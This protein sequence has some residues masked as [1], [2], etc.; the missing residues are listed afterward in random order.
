M[1]P[2]SSH[3]S[4]GCGSGRLALAATAIAL[5]ALAVAAPS[6]RATTG[7]AEP[8]TGANPSGCVDDAGAGADLF[9]DHFVVRHAENYS[10]TYADTYKVLTVAETSPGAGGHTY[11]L[12]QCGT[13]APDLDGDL[14]GAVV[15]TIPVATMFSESTSHDGFIDVLGLADALTGVADGSWVVTPS[16]RERIDAGA[17]ASFNPT[18]EIDTELVI[19][20][21]PDVYLT[22]GYDDPAHTT[23]AEAGIPVVANAEWLETS[24][25]GWAEWVGVF[26]ALTNTEARATGLYDG[27][28]DDYDATAA[29]VADIAD[30]PSVLSGSLY[31]GTWYA[32]GGGGIVA[33]FIADAGGDYVYADDTGTGSL[34]LDVEDVL[35]DGA[36]ADVWVNPTAGFTDEASAVATDS[37]YGELAAWDVGGVWSNA[38]PPTPGVSA[39]EQGPVM[40]AEYLR[41][42]AQIFHPELIPDRA[43]VFY[44]RLPA[45]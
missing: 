14:A 25:Q 12:V 30:R 13:D 35:A 20:D 9:P 18:G 28:V 7:P 37:R 8:D 40:I 5:S 42:Y 24:P 4:D 2:T 36:D 43:L 19:A 1:H 33:R 27:W 22:G 3:R 17:V 11:V 26:A 29:L 23:I 39:I 44:T 38:T 21:D 45:T 16:I 34:T 41:D 32:S 10:L 31:E 6:A 15:V